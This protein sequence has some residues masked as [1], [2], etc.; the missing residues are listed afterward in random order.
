MT[1]SPPTRQENEYYGLAREMKIQQ[2][3]QDKPV[4]SSSNLDTKLANQTPFD[5]NTN[6][7]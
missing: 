7:K 1:V 6:R 3:C 2:L 5:L 4:D